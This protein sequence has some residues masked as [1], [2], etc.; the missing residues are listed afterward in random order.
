M[1]EHLD[2][3]ALRPSVVDGKRQDDDYE[4]VWRDLQVGRILKPAGEAHWWWTCNVFGQPLM[5][6][7]RGQG[8]DFKDSQ[9]RFQIAWTRI[10]AGLTEGD[11]AVAARHGAE[12]AARQQPGVQPKSEETLILDHNRAAPRQRVLKQGTIEFH[13]GGIDCIV[14]NISETGAAL[15][16]ASPMGIPAEF[17][18]VI[19]GDHAKHSC[20][21]VW[22]K[23]KRV[24]VTF[25]K[26]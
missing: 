4:V 6:N 20:T 11:I 15:E 7:D 12:I 18:L 13:G 3:I 21:V 25:R 5:Q 1:T 17:T 24:G 26:D 19:A 8:I 16:V 14:R 22:R 23:E 10:K 2:T 9:V